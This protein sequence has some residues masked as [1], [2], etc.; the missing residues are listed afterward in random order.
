MDSCFCYWSYC[1][2]SLAGKSSHKTFGPAT[3]VAVHLFNKMLEGDF[4]ESSRF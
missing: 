3:G 2:L 4:Y 1:C